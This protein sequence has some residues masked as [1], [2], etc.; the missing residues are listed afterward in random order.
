[1]EYY[2]SEDNEYINKLEELYDNL[3]DK[4]LIQLLYSF[5]REFSQLS[6]NDL[7]QIPEE[8]GALYDEIS[9]YHYVFDA[10]DELENQGFFIP[11]RYRRLFEIMRDFVDEYERLQS[12]GQIDEEIDDLISCDTSIKVFKPY[13][14]FDM[15][16]LYRFMRDEGIVD[17]VNEKQ[18]TECIKQANI[19]PLWDIT[20]SKNMF[21]LVLQGLKWYYQDTYERRGR[22]NPTWYLKCCDS[23]GQTPLDM[24]RMNIPKDKRV[25]FCEKLRGSI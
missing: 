5:P 18:F 24:G 8:F 11:S 17:G 12:I 2:S 14:A 9:P 15:S 10:L 3:E 1:M 19:K 20:K 22:K 4:G 16:G 25:K 13:T 6:E 21:K 7:A 23:I